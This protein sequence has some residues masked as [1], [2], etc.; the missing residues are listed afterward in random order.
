MIPPLNGAKTHP[1]KPAAFDALR[2]I[3]RRPLPPQEFNPGVV[4][5]LCRE[6]LVELVDMQSPYADHGRRS[7]PHLRITAA[8]RAALVE[9]GRA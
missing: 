3:A 7:I 4:N 8:G 1:L 5:R 9:G 2:Q 6:S